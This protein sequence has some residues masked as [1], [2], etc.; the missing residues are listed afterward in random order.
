MFHRKNLMSSVNNVGE[1]ENIEGEKFH[2]KIFHATKAVP[3]GVDHIRCQPY[4]LQAS[5]QDALHIKTHVH[6]AIYCKLWC[7]GYKVTI[8]T[9]SKSS[10]FI[11][12][13]YY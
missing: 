3:Q 11:R 8:T 7:N 12:T 4:S 5:V 9:L 13:I 10:S 1:I 6:E 2:K